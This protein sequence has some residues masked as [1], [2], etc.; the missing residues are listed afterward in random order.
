MSTE[1]QQNSL[2]D[3]LRNLAEDLKPA[4]MLLLATISVS[5]AGIGA[6]AIVSAVILQD[7]GW[8]FIG[9]MAM[10]AGSVGFNVLLKMHL[11]IEAAER[12]ALRS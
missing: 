11:A 4:A 12:E 8:L 10:I 9:T 7:S 5:V 2:A 3:F 1:V 6:L